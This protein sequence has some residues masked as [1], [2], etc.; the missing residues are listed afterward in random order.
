MPIIFVSCLFVEV[1]L[2]AGEGFEPSL[3][4]PEPVVLAD[5]PRR[6]QTRFSE[7]ALDLLVRLLRDG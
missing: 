5:F 2:A 6:Q 3:T 1:S 7:H 4:D